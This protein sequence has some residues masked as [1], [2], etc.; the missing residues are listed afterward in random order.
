MGKTDPSF[1]SES[2]Y[3]PF[4]TIKSNQKNPR[5][6]EGKN[7]GY[8][9]NEWEEPISPIEKA[10]QISNNGVPIKK[11]NNPSNH[12]IQ[13]ELNNPQKIKAPETMLK[14]PSKN[15]YEQPVLPV[16]KPGN[17]KQNPEPNVEFSNHDPSNKNPYMGKNSQARD[18]PEARRSVASKN[19]NPSDRNRRIPKQQNAID[20]DDNGTMYLELMVDESFDM[21]LNIEEVEDGNSDEMSDPE[22][23]VNG[24][25]WLTAGEK[26]FPNSRLAKIA[27]K[28]LKA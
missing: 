8:E 6:P 15:L 11:S 28:N 16:G 19:T 26:Y 27:D 24:K 17:L 14:K 12:S 2:E 4:E 18:T 9:E 1:P 20:D 23:E 7:D 21:D 25:K 5:I 13:E 3:H 10:P 22:I